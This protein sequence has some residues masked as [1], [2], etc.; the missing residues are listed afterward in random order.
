MYFKFEI[1]DHFSVGALGDSFFEYLLKVWLLNNRTDSEL[2]NVY[3]LAVQAIEKHLLFKSKPNNLWY[4]AEKKSSRIEHKMAHL[5]C[6]IGGMFALQSKYETDP[7]KQRHYLE[8][9]EKIAD[10]CHESY[11]RAGKILS[12]K[13]LFKLF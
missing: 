11:I 6:F 1:L 2:K 13:I 9:A 12:Y 10:T 8:L 3:D 7:E 4:F 5:T